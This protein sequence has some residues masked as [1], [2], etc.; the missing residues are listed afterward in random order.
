MAGPT[1]GPVVVPPVIVPMAPQ[2]AST[3][4]AAARAAAGMA[5]CL[6]IVALSFFSR[7]RLQGQSL[8]LRYSFQSSARMRGSVSSI[9]ARRIC[10]SSTLSLFGAGMSS[11]A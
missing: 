2:P 8:Y 1:A 11:G 7:E 6:R 5:L 10:A 9:A 3:A 4:T